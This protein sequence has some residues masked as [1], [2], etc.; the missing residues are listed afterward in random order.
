MKQEKLQ[1]LWEKYK[2]TIPYVIFGVLTTVVNI[3]V[4]WFFYRQLHVWMMVSNIIAW[5][6]SVLFA[7][8]TNRKWVFHSEAAS[9][10][11]YCKEITAFFAARLATGVLDW[12]IMFIF[13]EK[14]GFND[15]IMKIV[16]NIVVIIL[17]YVA[18]K[19]WIFKSKNSK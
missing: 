4:F 13:A 2:D 14:M 12:L 16:A 19:F 7:Y 8:L 6:A 18:S 10:A 1:Q 9:F 5:F 3:G 17:N 11:D 15:M